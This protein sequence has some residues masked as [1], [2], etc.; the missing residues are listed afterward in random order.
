MTDTAAVTTALGDVTAPAVSD[1]LVPPPAM[2]VEQAQARRVQFIADPALREGVV[3]GDPKIVDEWKKINSA[4]VPK[5]DA[6]DAEAREYAARQAALAPLKMTAG[7]MDPLFWDGVATRAHVSLAE[8][9]TALQTWAAC[10]RDAAWVARCV[11]GGM[12]ENALKMR[13]V[14]ILAAP[15]GTPELVERDRLAG[16]KRVGIK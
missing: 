16:L 6:P 7:P 1:L 13:I 8:R 14:G 12:E 5:L 4:L 15:V 10:K 9:E 3:R 11:A 2:T